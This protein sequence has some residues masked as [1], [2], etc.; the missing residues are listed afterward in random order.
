MGAATPF[1]VAGGRVR[2]TLRAPLSKR[3]AHSWAWCSVAPM[4]VEEIVPVENLAI[5][6]NK[7]A[8]RVER[9]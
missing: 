2:N 4:E 6:R 1:V 5:V 8:W 9:S 7:I 3:E